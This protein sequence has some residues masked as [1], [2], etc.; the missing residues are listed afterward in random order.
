MENDMKYVKSVIC[1]LFIFIL[2]VG[3]GVLVTHIFY[4][5]RMEQFL[6]GDPKVREEILLKRLSRKLALD[7]RQRERVRAIVEE[8]REEMKNIRKQFRPQMEAVLA[9]SRAEMRKILRPEQEEKFEQFV[10]RHKARHEK[11]E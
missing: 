6:R 7:E 8:T 11:D 1:V 9:K 4:K 10:T 2:G 5:S 3:S